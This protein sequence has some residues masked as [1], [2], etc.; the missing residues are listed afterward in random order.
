[1]GGFP[2]FIEDAFDEVE[3]AR[4]PSSVAVIDAAGEILWTNP[5][6]HDFAANNGAAGESVRWQSYFEPIAGPL[7]GYYE[8]AFAAA[9]RTGQVFEQDYEC[10]TPEQRRFFRLR[11]LPIRQTMLLVEHAIVA[12]ELREDRPTEP[13][14]EPAYRNEHGLL[15]QCSNC[16]RTRNPTTQGFDW[17]AAWVERCPSRTS[18]GV[19]PTCAGFYWGLAEG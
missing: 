18:H 10:S 2:T 16:R 3:L 4:L 5:A 15:V 19:C 9:L 11:A 12:G 8:S 13:P 1:M 7:R 14:P 17:V 6:W